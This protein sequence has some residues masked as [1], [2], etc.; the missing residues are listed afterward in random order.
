MLLF[1]RAFIPSLRIL[2][3]GTKPAGF[4]HGKLTTDTRGSDTNDGVCGLVYLGNW[5]FLD[6]HIEGFPFECDGFHC[7]M[8]VV[9][10]MMIMMVRVG[11][12]HCDR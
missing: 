12:L 11:V 8:V 4:G 3:R 7:F 6:R 5:E 9:V 2:E 1:A 10:I